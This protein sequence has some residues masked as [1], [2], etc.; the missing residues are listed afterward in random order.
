MVPGV[1]HATTV[2]DALVVGSSG[3]RSQVHRRQDGGLRKHRVRD[4][5]GVSLEIL[6]HFTFSCPDAAVRFFNRLAADNKWASDLVVS[7]HC[8]GKCAAPILPEQTRCILPFAQLVE[9]DRLLD[10][11][12]VEGSHRFFLS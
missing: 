3:R 4:A 9:A 12:T 11:T 1:L 2:F 10:W 5:Y 6:W 7:G 8:S